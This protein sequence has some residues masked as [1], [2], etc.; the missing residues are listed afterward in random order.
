MIDKEQRAELQAMLQSEVPKREIF[1]RLGKTDDLATAL[2]NAPYLS[3]RA[4]FSNANWVLVAL[5]VFLSASTAILTVANVVFLGLPLYLLI[6]GLFNPVIF[7]Y[8][9]WLVEKFEG[10]GYLLAAT[11][12]VLFLG[13]NVAKLGESTYASLLLVAVLLVA[14]TAIGL[15]IYLRLR[16]CPQ[17]GFLGAKT[18]SDGQYLFLKDG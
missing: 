16:L 17:A 2:V 7:L 12:S 9:A 15:S 10:A 18:D 11:F 5:L 4:R 14:A 6:L 8:C 3:D 1:V 13:N